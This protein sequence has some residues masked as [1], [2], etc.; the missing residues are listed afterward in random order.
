[1]GYVLDMSHWAQQFS[2]LTQ[3][4][5]G[6]GMIAKLTAV[7]LAALVV[8]GIAVSRISNEIA[9]IGLAISALAAFL[10]F[11][12]ITLR[13]AE[14]NPALAVTEGKTYVETKQIELAA[15]G[16]VPPPAVPGPDPQNPTLIIEA[17]RN[18][19]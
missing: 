11:A 10:I 16:F 14:K 17:M 12:L 19:E 13:W 7:G 3:I 5:T 15:K 4:R 1:M 6:H 18:D 2:W 8:V 9:I